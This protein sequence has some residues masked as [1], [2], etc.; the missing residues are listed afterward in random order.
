MTL[1]IGALVQ[2]AGLATL[3]LG[4][5]I[6]RVGVM[7]PAVLITGL[8]LASVHRGGIGLSIKATPAARKGWA[9]SLF[10]GCAYFAANFPVIGFG[11]VA[12]HLGM[13]AALISYA[14]LFGLLLIGSGCY[15]LL[16]RLALP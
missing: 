4:L 10:L 15:A 2:T 8:G 1:A 16:K 12:D 6:D 14:T 5:A 13:L 7:L 9:I 3:V 11:V